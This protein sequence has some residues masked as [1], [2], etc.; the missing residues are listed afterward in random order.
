MTTVEAEGI[1]SKSWL[2]VLTEKQ[3]DRVV[4]LHNTE[5]KNDATQLRC[6]STIISEKKGCAKPVIMQAGG[7]RIYRKEDKP[8]TSKFHPKRSSKQPTPKLLK[9]L[10]TL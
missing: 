9:C 1:N 8:L 2:F 3:T 10:A 5:I 7:N 6:R 4:S